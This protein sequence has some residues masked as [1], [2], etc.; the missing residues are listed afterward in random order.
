MPPLLPS[1][2]VP[3]SSD[4]VGVTASRSRLRVPA[5]SP[6]F[7]LRSIIQQ[8]PPGV[9]LYVG[10]RFSDLHVNSTLPL[11]TSRADLDPPERVGVRVRAWVR[12][13]ARVRVRSGVGLVWAAHRRFVR[14]GTQGD[15]I[16]ESIATIEFT[17][18]SK[19]P[20]H[21]Q[22]LRATSR[23]PSSTS[24]PRACF[25]KFVPRGEVPCILGVLR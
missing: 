9:S 3:Q 10:A 25:L 16:H 17:C 8:Y 12:V 7:L 14:T 22:E 21:V 5:L 6:F 15:A 18:Q 1:T 19:N 23:G 2:A 13:R 4:R 20:L 24:V 11:P